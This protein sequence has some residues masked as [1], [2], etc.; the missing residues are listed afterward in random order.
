MLEKYKFKSKDSR[1]DDIISKDCLIL[2]FCIDMT[3]LKVL[4]FFIFLQQEVSFDSGF[5]IFNNLQ[6]RVNF[7]FILINRKPIQIIE[8]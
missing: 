4:S 7:F 8:T 1:T 5:H 6:I 3:H 2:T